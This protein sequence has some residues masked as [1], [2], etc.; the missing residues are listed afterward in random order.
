MPEAERALAIDI[1]NSRICCGLFIGGQLNE[2]WNYSTADPA[3][4]S[5]H[6][7]SLHNKY[8]RGLI[9]VSSVVP[10]VLPSI[11]EQWPNARQNI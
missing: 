1:G 8:G 9:A 5:S 11:I 10:G 6:L 4:A 7:N 3:T 2:T